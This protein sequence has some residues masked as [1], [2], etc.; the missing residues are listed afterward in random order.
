[1]MGR[2]AFEAMWKSLPP[3]AETKT[4]VECI[5][6]K[7]PDQLMVQLTQSN[8]FHVLQMKGKEGQCVMYFSGKLVNNIPILVG[9]AVWAGGRADV[10]LKSTNAAL[11]EPFHAS[12]NELLTE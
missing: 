7:S 8:L 5:T 6:A 11:S 2:V 3:E 10:A 4:Q 9:I 1:M 12:M